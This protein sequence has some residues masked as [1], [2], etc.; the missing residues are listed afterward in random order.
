MIFAGDF[1][2][3]SALEK[4]I[5]HQVTTVVILHENM[6][7]QSQTEDD[8]KLWTALSNM[9]YKA[10]TVQDIEFLA[11]Q[12]CGSS[13]VAPDI[14]SSEFRNVSIITGLNVQKD[15][16]NRI[17]TIQFA[18]ETNQ[19]LVHFFSED[20]ISENV[21]LAQ[22][23]HGKSSKVTILSP[24]IQIEL[25]NS[26]PSANNKQ[27]PAKLSLCKGLPIMIRLNTATELGI[28]KGQEAFVYSWVEGTGTRGQRVLQTLFV[29]LAAPPEPIHIPGLPEN[30][31]PLTRT[32]VEI[33][34][35]FAM[36]DYCSQGKTRPWNVVDLNNCRSHQS[37]YTALSRSASSHAF[38]P[39]KIQGIC[40]ELELLDHI[41]LLQYTGQ[42]PLSVCVLF[43]FFNIWNS[44]PLRYTNQFN[45]MNTEWLGLLAGCFQKH[46]D[47]KY[48]L[49]EV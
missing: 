21:N 41:T 38:D 37:Y 22:V 9:R 34:P 24:Q 20:M 14:N 1:A 15:E 12:V 43:I 16:I 45:S 4:A 48:T 42:L 8:S 17:D 13:L 46:I 30:V 47:N 29:K 6:C 26:L 32:S 33:I 36:T 10:C 27:I 3:D 5:W 18:Q 44:N 11:S 28:T 35:N 7:Q 19:E 25:W 31:V 39:K 23:K 40:S 2:Q 49:E